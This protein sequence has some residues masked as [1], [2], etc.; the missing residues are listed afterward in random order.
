[1]FRITPIVKHFIIINV[2]MFA[3]TLL[4]ENFMLEKYVI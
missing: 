4:A 1:M 3:L 2:I